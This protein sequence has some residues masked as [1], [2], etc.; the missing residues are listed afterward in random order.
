MALARAT[1]G[2][3]GYQ[4]DVSNQG[5][6]AGGGFGIPKVLLDIAKRRAISQAQKD[7]LA[8]EMDKEALKQAKK[9]GNVRAPRPTLRDDARI[10]AETQAATDAARAASAQARAL[11]ERAPMRTSWIMGAGGHPTIDIPKLTGAQRQVFLP[12]GSSF[13]GP[14][15]ADLD[16][17][18]RKIS[19]EDMARL[20]SA[21]AGRTSPFG[22]SPT[23]YGLSLLD[24]NDEEA[25][26]RRSIRMNLPSMFFGLRGRQDEREA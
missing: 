26:F 12:Q 5:A 2:G 13:E 20:E 6:A 17:G 19:I 7:K 23:Q 10:N 4:T 11:T 22:G 1:Y 3:G 21:G 15:L 14:S 8:L 18:R 25:G 16:A 9:A 24:P